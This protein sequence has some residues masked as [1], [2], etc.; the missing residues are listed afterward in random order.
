ML[1][2]ISLD[3]NPVEWR[4]ERKISTRRHQNGRLTQDKLSALTARFRNALKKSVEGIVEAGRVLIQ[5]KNELEH[6]EFMDWVVNELRFGTRKAGVRDADIRKA[7]MLMFLARH[8]VISKSCHWHDF[9]PSLR[10]LWELTQ[11]RPKQRLLDLIADGTINPG[12]TREEAIALR[13][14]TSQERSPTPKLKREI[15]ALL[16]VCIIFGGGDGVLA[17]IRD[18]KDVSSVPPPQ[19]ID[20]AARWVKRKLAERRRSE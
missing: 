3:K 6:G 18:L 12:M 13:H 14:R 2:R 10:T 15:A 4:P 7:E 5:A 9:P 1:E 16:E 17:H 19:E 8:E 20:R 11:I